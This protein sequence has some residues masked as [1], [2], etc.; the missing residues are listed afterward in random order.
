MAFTVAALVRLAPTV[1]LNE[2]ARQQLQRQADA[3]LHTRPA[4]GAATKDT[5]DTTGV[6]AP[7][8]EVPHGNPLDTGVRIQAGSGPI[9][10]KCLP[11]LATGRLHSPPPAAANA[12]SPGTAKSRCGCAPG[13][14]S[15]T[16]FQATEP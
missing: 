7:V 10:S 12:A 9:G 15:G 11:P 1:A 5:T 2:L 3:H 16:L 4:A 13:P 8:V 6:S 14:I